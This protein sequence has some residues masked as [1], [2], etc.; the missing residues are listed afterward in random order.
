MQGTAHVSIDDPES[1]PDLVSFLGHRRRDAK[2]YGITVTDGRVDED[3]ARAVLPQLVVVTV[4]CHAAHR[5]H[6]RRAEPV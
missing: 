4:T 5:Q 3:D 6:S 2:A 1:L